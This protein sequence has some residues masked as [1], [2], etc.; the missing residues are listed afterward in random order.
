MTGCTNKESLVIQ[1]FVIFWR[2]HLKM[3]LWYQ[4]KRPR[5]RLNVSLFVGKIVKKKGIVI[6]R[7]LLS[8]VNTHQWVTQSHQLT[9][10]WTLDCRCYTGV[11]L[12][13]LLEA[14]QTN[15]KWAINVG[16]T[17]P[18]L[19]ISQFLQKL[20]WLVS[21]LDNLCVNI[22]SMNDRVLCARSLVAGL[23]FLPPIRTCYISS[24]RT[25]C[26]ASDMLPTLFWVWE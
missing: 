6:A 21:S 3:C 1:S 19:S 2:W 18:P 25:C 17:D 13:F 14:E 8:L 11:N 20:L 4:F 24:F 26:C 23:L 10:T 15:H 7:H 5:W 16:L 12:S 22:S 9:N